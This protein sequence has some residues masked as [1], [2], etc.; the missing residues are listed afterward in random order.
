MGANGRAYEDA[1]F[2]GR[3][4][5]D[6]GALVQ[7]CLQGVFSFLFELLLGESPDKNWR[8]VPDNLE[9][10]GWRQLRNIDFHVCVSVVSGP[11]IQ[12][13]HEADGIESGEV[14]HTCI[15]NCC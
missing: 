5:N 14:Q 9:H 8:S 1:S 6:L 10:L 11:A 12:P 2:S 13:S 4:Q 15:V 3:C 7:N